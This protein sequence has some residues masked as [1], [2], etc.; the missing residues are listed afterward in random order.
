MKFNKSKTCSQAVSQRDA[1]NDAGQFAAADA[2]NQSSGVDSSSA[3][4]PHIDAIGG[5]RFVAAFAVLISHFRGKFGFGDFHTAFTGRGVSFFFVLSGFI[6]TYVY[7]SRLKR[8]GILSFYF[9]RI[10]RLWPLHLVCTLIIVWLIGQKIYPLKFGVNLLLL[11][12]WIP[13][14]RWSLSYNG[15]AWSISTEMFFFFMFPF[16]L[17]GGQRQFWWKFAIVTLTSFAI[18][19]GAHY[20]YLDREF[21]NKAMLV[22][23]I[24]TN[25][26][27][28][29]VEFA[30]G[31][32]TAW[33][34][35]NSIA[36]KA[37][38]ALT[39]SSH[40]L[41]HDTLK[42]VLAMSTMVVFVFTYDWARQSITSNGSH[43]LSIWYHFAGSAPVFA[44]IIFVFARSQGV[45][46]RAMGSKAMNFLGE[47]S[48]A[49][50]LIHS[51]ILV[52]HV[53]L[54]WS[55]SSP[56]RWIVAA[57]VILMVLG[58]SIWLHFVIEKPFR[59]ALMSVSQKGFPKSIR[60]SIAQVWRFGF[61]KIGFACLLLCLTSWVGI[62]SQYTPLQFT[63]QMYQTIFASSR[64]VRGT[65]F[66]DRI[67]LMGFDAKAV[68]GG[69]ELSFVW[70]KLAPMKHHRFTHILDSQQNIALILPPDDRSFFKEAELFQPLTEVQFIP[71]DQFNDGNEVAIG[72]YCPDIDPQT[73]A[74]L[75]SLRSSRSPTGFFHARLSVV[76]PEMLE[77][78]K[79]KIK[80]SQQ[81][82]LA[83]EL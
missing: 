75:G 67:K 74:P 17:L 78:L 18:V 45:C 35:I 12:S 39:E 70:Q 61:S 27:V 1:F 16:L 76:P 73:N 4:P 62:R 8:T 63:P 40:R 71:V 56:N 13:D 26:V 79:E 10:V 42:E 23:I 37:S 22:S 3:K 83:E 82:A 55:A 19:G 14:R 34:F 31:M 25:P 44:V 41:W 77:R 72:F 21:T 59:D 68:E 7:H 66:G 5:F 54:D 80:K 51:I 24:H 65:R 29:L 9:K 15:V 48:Y 52:Y 50:F 47:I 6:L 53:N 49:F 81:V 43:L 11:Q 36:R 38:A 28:R 30:L 46:A 32:A 57:S 58:S 33:I 20:F 60:N 69:I 2:T 64:S